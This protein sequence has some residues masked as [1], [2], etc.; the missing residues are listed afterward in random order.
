MKLK[1]FERKQMILAGVAANSESVSDMDIAGLWDRFIDLCPTIPN[2]VNEG[3]NYELHI[4]EERAKK[5]HFCLIGV[6]VSQIAALPIEVF[7]KVIPA[8]KYALYTHHFKDG[9]YG[10][11]LKAMYDWLAA[12]EYKSAHAFDIQCYDARFKGPDDPESVLKILV[13]VELKEET[14]KQ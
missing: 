9:G 13:P 4:E 6:E 5:M 7:Y 1:I 3:V 12:S 10:Q 2:Q 11:A 14:L 8:G